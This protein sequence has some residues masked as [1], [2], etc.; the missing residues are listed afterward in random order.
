[1]MRFRVV[2]RY[3]GLTAVLHWNLAAIRLYQEAGENEAASFV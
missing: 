2:A 1:M 3:W